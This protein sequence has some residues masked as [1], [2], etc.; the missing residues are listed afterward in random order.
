MGG[1]AAALAAAPT[2]AAQLRADFR[3]RCARPDAQPPGDRAGLHHL[4]GPRRR[5]AGVH[6]GLAARPAAGHLPRLCDLALQCRRQILPAHN[7]D[8]PHDPADRGRHRHPD[9]LRD[10]HPLCHDGAVR[11]PRQPVRHLRGARPHLHGHDAALRHLDDADLHR[12][13]ALHAR[14]R[15]PPHGGG[16]HRGDPAHRPP[17]RGIGHGGDIPVRLHPELGGVPAG[18][19]ADPSGGHD[20]DGAAQQV[21]ERGGGAPLRTA[22]R[23][24]HGSHHP[25]GDPRAF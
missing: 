2:D 22:G 12:R 13:G 4:E 7:P 14:A 3:L 17:A 20:A 10:H 24:R 23:H 21:P 15:R 9:L 19:D 18:A 25:G 11:R 16:P 6:D 5:R 1:L 8:D